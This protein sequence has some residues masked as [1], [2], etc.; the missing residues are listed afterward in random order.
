MSSRHN[1]VLDS[2]PRYG[3]AVKQGRFQAQKIVYGAGGR[4]VVKPLSDWVSMREAEDVIRPYGWV[5]YREQ[6]AMRQAQEVQS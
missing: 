5:P 1:V 4:S 2:T 6:K 3:I